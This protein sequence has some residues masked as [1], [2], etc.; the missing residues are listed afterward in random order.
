MRKGVFI[1]SMLAW[2]L[3]AVSMTVVP[4]NEMFKDGKVQGT[5][6]VKNF[7]TRSL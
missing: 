3:F 4:P 2:A 7:V 6:E 5:I 1:V